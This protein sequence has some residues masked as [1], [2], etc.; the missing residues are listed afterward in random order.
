MNVGDTPCICMEYCDGGDLRQVSN[1]LI[2]RHSG[3]ERSFFPLPQTPGYEAKLVEFVLRGNPRNKSVYSTRRIR[4]ETHLT[5]SPKICSA[6]R[7]VLGLNQAAYF[8][9]EK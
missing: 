8:F 1:S 2:P 7:S 9:F 5:N 4:N 6:C 3:E